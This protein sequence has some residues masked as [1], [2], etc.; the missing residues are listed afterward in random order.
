MERLEDFQPRL[1]GAVLIGTVTDNSAVEIHLF[2]DSPEIVAIKLAIDGVSPHDVQRRC[3]FGGQRV[4]QL[5]GFT[6]E[7]D[8]ELD[9]GDR[10]PDARGAS[11]AA[12][13]GRPRPMRRAER[14]AVLALLADDV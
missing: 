14:D 11:R 6:F 7:S 8:G 2:A 9:R 5:P 4:A 10:V 13:A 12:F 1:V 3:R